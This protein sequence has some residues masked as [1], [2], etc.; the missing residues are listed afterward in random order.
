MIDFSV[1]LIELIVKKINQ[2]NKQTNFS[3]KANCLLVGLNLI[4]SSGCSGIM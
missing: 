3:F 1:D 4:K 2:A